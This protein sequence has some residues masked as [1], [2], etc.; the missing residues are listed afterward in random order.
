[1]PR[2]SI[3][4]LDEDDFK[5]VPVKTAHS[6]NILGFVESQEIES[7]YYLNSHYLEPEELG[8]KPFC[9][10]KRGIN[11]DQPRRHSQGYLPKA[12]ASLCLKTVRQ[13]YGRCIR[14]TI[15]MK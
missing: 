8:V 12:R 14:C 7:I 13:H 3:I 10:T 6:I 5:K 9:F 15:R 1:M 2:T 4:V 11:Q